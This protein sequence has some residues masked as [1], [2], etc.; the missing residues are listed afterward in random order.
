MNTSEFVSVNGVS[1]SRED[2]RRIIT[3]LDGRRRQYHSRAARAHST[4][5]SKAER[6]KGARLDELIRLLCY[7]SNMTDP[8]DERVAERRR[9]RSREKRAKR[10][11]GPS[12][13][14][15]RGAAPG[16]RET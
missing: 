3:E 7:A 16:V 8:S 6:T 5:A 2:W 1:F 10:G 15:V 4:G 12:D 9:E 14:R 11:R 13:G